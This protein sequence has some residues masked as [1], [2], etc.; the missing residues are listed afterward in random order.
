MSSAEIKG[1][2]VSH[3]YNYAAYS[4]RVKKEKSWIAMRRIVKLSF[5]RMR[6]FFTPTAPLSLAKE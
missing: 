5:V 4:K 3:S 1:V 6:N 2:D